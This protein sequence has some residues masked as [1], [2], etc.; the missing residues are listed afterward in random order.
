[1]KEIVIMKSGKSIREV[2]YPLWLVDV[3]LVKKKMVTVL[4][5]SI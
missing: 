4:I 3:V 5:S 1:M 2:Q